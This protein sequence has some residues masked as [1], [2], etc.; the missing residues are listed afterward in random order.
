[1]AKE[2]KFSLVFRDMW[3]AAGKY[4]PRVDQLVKVAPAI[5]KMGCFDRVETNGGGFEQVNLLFGENPNNAVRQWTKPFHEAGI[6]T[7]MLDRALNGLRMSPVPADVRKL[8]YKVKHAQGTDITRI[9]CGLNDAR[10]VIPSIKYA[11][12]AGMIAQASLCI[13]SSPIHTVD[14]YVD[15][16]KKFIEAGCD[17]IC[18][19][20]MAGIGRPV[21]LGEL[22]RRIKEIKDITIQYHSH[23]GPGFNMAS[24]LEVCKAGCD[25]VDV[26]MEPLSWGTGHADV[27][28]VRE[29]LKDAGFKVKDINMSAYMEVRTL[30]QE[31]MD[32]FL[33][34]YIPARNRQM[35]SLLIG[36]GLPGGMMGSLMTDLET[37]LESI[38]KWKEKNGKPKMTQDE[39]LI[40]LFDEVKYVWPMMGYP[41]L[42]T[43]FSQY[44][45]NMALMN[46][47]QME[48]GKERWSMIAD[49]IWDM[50]LGKSGKLPGDLAPELIAKAKEQ[51]REFHTEDPQSNYPDALDTFR[52]EM[53]REGWDFGKDD[54]E[55]F[56]L[57]MHPQQYRAMKSGKAKADFE[58]YLAERKAKKQNAGGGSMTFPQTVVVEVKGEKY[59]VTIGAND[60]KSVPAAASSAA[61]AATTGTGEGNELTSPL[62]GKFYLVKG[63]GDTPVKVGDT[64]KKGQTVCYVEAMKTFNAI[65]S[66]WD[67]VVTEIC[68]TSGSSVSEDDVLMKIK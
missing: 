33:G 61:P 58:A 45:K 32:D 23:A 35:N 53:Q 54:E 7:H 49:D 60:G 8:F 10:N 44:V 39:L 37:N 1:M 50:M 57:A 47:M 22:T 52:E 40:K 4:V 5:I 64:V 18:L 67:G 6:Q 14:Y 26:G 46:V 48:K 25:Y 19:K 41:C 55:L 27:I 28:A 68:L 12:E 63:A 21:F 30:I 62:E 16:A 29:M 20:D 36:P 2:V 31:M 15:L 38:N 17:E 11:K 56:E 24:I 65:A 9:F 34:Y 43:P 13:T 59:S 51:G 66:E 42:V 3:Q